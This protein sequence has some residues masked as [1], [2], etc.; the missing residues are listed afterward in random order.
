MVIFH[1]YFYVYRCYHWRIIPWIVSGS[2]WLVAV[3]HGWSFKLVLGFFGSE[4]WLVVSNILFISYMGSNPII[5]PI[6]ELIFF[7]MVIAPPNR[8]LCQLWGNKPPRLMIGIGA[9]IA[10]FH[11]FPDLNH[12]KNH[13]VVPATMIR[14]LTR[15]FQNQIPMFEMVWF[16]NAYYHVTHSKT[17]RSTII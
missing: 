3:D 1:S 2:P 10:R 16:D 14:R 12:D 5:L 8:K 17:C 15:I 7:K 4:S 9:I 11:P 6:D 13:W